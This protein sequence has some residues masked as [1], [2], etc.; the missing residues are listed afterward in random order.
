[1]TAKTLAT[2]Q[3][4][5]VPT[6]DATGQ[7]NCNWVESYTLTVPPAW[8]SGV[9][10]VKLTAQTSGYQAYIIFT[11]REDSRSSDLYFQNSVTTWQAYN[12]WGGRSLYYFPAGTV[13]ATK[14]SFNRPYAGPTVNSSVLKYG[15]GAG[16]FFVMIN[17]DARP[18]WEY[19]A[20]RWMEKQGYDLTYCTSIDTHQT[21]PAGKIVKAFVSVGHD[22]YWSAAM[23]SNVENARDSST[24]PVNLVFLGSNVSSWRIDFTDTYLRAFTC[25]KANDQDFWA[26]PVIH[27][28]EYTMVGVQYI[29]NTYDLGMVI[30]SGLSHWAFANCSCYVN[31]LTVQTTLPGLLGY[32]LDG[33]WV[34]NYCRDYLTTLPTCPDFGPGQY[35]TKKLADTMYRSCSQGI[36]PNQT[37]GEGHA[38]MTM[39]TAA[40]GPTQS[41]HAQVFA[42]GSMQWNWGLDDFGYYT[43]GFYGSTRVNTIARQMTHNVLRTF[44]GKTPPGTPIP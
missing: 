25:Y 28:P 38:Y 2:K 3:T 23:R 22:E 13:P 7:V 15:T 43:K 36:D 42:T 20:L 18:G 14:V 40:N 26:G 39:Y 32:E 44:S 37:S 41:A 33:C 11:V 29:D 24:R 27:N 8:R 5:T 4:Q 12:P 31:N 1:V 10:V 34:G 17:D 21:W 9:Y 35:Q 16:E 30:P 19:N 6:P